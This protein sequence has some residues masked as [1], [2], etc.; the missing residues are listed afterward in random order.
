MKYFELTQALVHEE[1]DSKPVV[2]SLWR[3][4]R[5]RL[6]VSLKSL[7]GSPSVVYVFQQ[8]SENTK[9]AVPDL[10]QSLTKIKITSNMYCVQDALLSTLS[11]VT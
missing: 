5:S 4:C 3:V 11:V 9:D 6:S 8:I 7:K 2:V 10:C 1:Q